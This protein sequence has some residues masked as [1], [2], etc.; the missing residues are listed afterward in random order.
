LQ[1]FCVCLQITGNIVHALDR[2]GKNRQIQVRK[3]RP[4]SCPW[5]S[6]HPPAMILP[7]LPPPRPWA[8]PLW[9]LLAHPQAEVD[10]AA[11]WLIVS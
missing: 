6:P 9:L 5:H 3:L 4:R 2:E 7:S 10:N 8:H 1:H 11:Y